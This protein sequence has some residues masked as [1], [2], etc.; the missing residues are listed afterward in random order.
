M[1]VKPGS[2]VSE[3]PICAG[4][5][6]EILDIL[7]SL[8][9]IWLFLIGPQWAWAWIPAGIVRTRYQSI[10][11]SWLVGRTSCNQKIQH[12]TK[13]AQESHKNRT[14]KSLGCWAL[15]QVR[16]C[17]ASIAW[18]CKAYCYYLAYEEHH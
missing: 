14:R 9:S 2:D 11:G 10:D 6:P 12:P 1:V 18:K 8:Y 7:G 17:V 5:S 3:T 15:H 4:V 13:M 16:G